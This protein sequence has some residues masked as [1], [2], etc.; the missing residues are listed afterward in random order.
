MPIYAVQWSESAICMHKAT[1]SWTSILPLPPT[2]SISVIRD[3]W[4]E[5]LVLYSRFPPVIHFTRGSVYLSMLV[6][7]F[8]LPS[9]TLLSPVSTCPFSRSASLF[10][11]CKQI[12]LY[13]FSRF[14]TYALLYDI[15][16]SLVALLLVLQ[17]PSIR[18]PR[19][20]SGK[21][22]PCNAGDINDAGFD[23][24]VG[25]IPWRRAWQPTPVILVWR[26]PWTEEP[27]GLQFLGS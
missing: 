2:P 13:H 9:P 16:I 11:C 21:E 10:L 4:A 24:W 14:H 17:G 6:S 18:L 7:Q 26:I 15:N 27:G 12:C 19:W 25:K 1:P 5:L 22:S 20:L 8:F 23:P 3:H